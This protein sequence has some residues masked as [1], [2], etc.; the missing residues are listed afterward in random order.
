M[1]HLFFAFCSFLYEFDEISCIFLI[2][3]Y[4]FKFAL[5]YIYIKA[6]TD[7]SIFFLVIIPPCF[8]FGDV[9]RKFRLAGIKHLFKDDIDSSITLDLYVR[10]LN[11]L[12]NLNYINYITGENGILFE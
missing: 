10:E 1:I 5:I 8:K 11:I 9:L 2:F 6:G 12:T 3:I 7:L 4:F